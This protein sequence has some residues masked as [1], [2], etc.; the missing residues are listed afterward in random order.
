MKGQNNMS[1]YYSANKIFGLL[2][3]GDEIENFQ[4]AYC[5]KNKDYLKHEFKDDLNDIDI[6]N[7]KELIDELMELTSESFLFN[8]DLHV[9]EE[10]EIEDFTAFLINSDQAEGMCFCPLTMIEDEDQWAKEIDEGLI[11][12][13]RMGCSE[14]SIL[15]GR[16]FYNSAEEVIEETKTRFGELLPEDFDY[17]THIGEF[18]YAFCA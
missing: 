10:N 12:P 17:M 4:K 1:M 14:I 6:N 9:D 3:T 11:I 13:A 2:L 18:W 8:E 7:E 5:L 16:P 15:A